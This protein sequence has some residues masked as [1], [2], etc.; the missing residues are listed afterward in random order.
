[1]ICSRCN[2]RTELR[3]C[4]QCRIV[5]NGNFTRN[6]FAEDMARKIFQEEEGSTA[7]QERAEEDV[8]EIRLPTYDDMG[9]PDYGLDRF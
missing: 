1:M 7:A 9:F 4:P 5:K 2:N 8:P 6:R 3:V